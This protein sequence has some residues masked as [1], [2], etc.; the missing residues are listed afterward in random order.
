MTGYAD[1][2]INSNDKLPNP[3]QTVLDFISGQPGFNGKAAAFGSWDVFPYILNAKRANYP[4][5]AGFDT[6]GSASPSGSLT[7]RERLLNRLLHEI[8][9]EWSSVRFD[10]FTHHYALEHLKKR[11]PRVLYVAYGETDDFAHGGAYDSYL[12]SAHQTDGFI[13]ELWDYAQSDPQYKGKTTFII[14]TD[15]GR[16]T[17]LPGAWRSHGASVE[18]ADEIWIAVIGPDTPQANTSIKGEYYQNQIAETVAAFLGLDFKT[19]HRSEEHTSELQSLMRISYAVF[20]L[21]K[22]N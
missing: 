10:A 4:I 21:K 22:N 6:V 3:N 20:C 19:P 1:K 11:H 7:E 13:Q 8:P 5:N 16:G 14:T 17:T 18:G 9:P 12:R 15:H 2:R